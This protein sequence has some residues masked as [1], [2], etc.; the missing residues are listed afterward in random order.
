M[1]T[2]NGPVAFTLF[3][4]QLNDAALES[5]TLSCSEGNGPRFGL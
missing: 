5:L 1:D 4:T 3:T 2:Y